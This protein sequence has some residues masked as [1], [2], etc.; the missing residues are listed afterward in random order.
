[1]T[2]RF[3]V[4][5][6]YQ[7]SYRV[8]RSRSVSP[9]R[10]TPLAGLRSDQMG[11]SREPQIHSRKKAGWA[12]PVQISS[13]LLWPSEPELPP[14]T[15]TSRISAQQP[16]RPRRTRTN[17]VEPP[18]TELGPSAGSRSS[19]AQEPPLALRP[20]SPPGHPADSGLAPGPPGRSPPGLEPPAPAPA[21]CSAQ[22]YPPQPDSQPQP[23]R[24]LTVVNGQQP[25]ANGVLHS[26]S[27]TAPSFKKNYVPMQT[28]YSWSFQGLALPCFHL[29]SNTR[30]KSHPQQEGPAL[31]REE[32]MSQSSQRATP[33][34]PTPEAQGGHRIPDVGGVRDSTTSLQV[35]ELREKAL[36]YRRR[37]WGTHF[38]RDHLNQLISEHTVLWEPTTS[39]AT[40]STPHSSPDPPTP[41]LT[42]ASPHLREEEPQDCERSLSCREEQDLRREEEEGRRPTPRMKIHRV[43][44]THHDRTTPATGGAILVSA[45]QLGGGREV[46]TRDGPVRK[47]HSPHRLQRPGFAIAAEVGTLDPLPL[48]PEEAW[49]DNSPVSNTSPNPDTC[50]APKSTES[51]T[52]KT[53]RIKHATPTPHRIQGTLRHPEF[54]HNGELGVMKVMDG[55]GGAGC[56]SDEDDRLTVMSWHSAA[57]CSVASVVL[58]RAQKRRDNF[59]G[60]R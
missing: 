16:T 55:C 48:R 13:S 5:S 37:A 59:W 40:C 1:M 41:H 9:Q 24:P 42:S 27:R 23:R 49:L 11:I 56:G 34:P 50:P 51:P 8:S 32:V 2:V 19:L 45:P 54:Q 38:S 46:W 28:E 6:E 52:S 44:R 20:P 15:R 26:N 29:Q 7:K 4:K 30:R 33:S 31:Q 25:V 43:Q 3:K 18:P 57:S 60:K 36:W 12:G 17:P 39:S 58:E 14:D 10:S 53:I 22:P 35:K 21:R 47:S